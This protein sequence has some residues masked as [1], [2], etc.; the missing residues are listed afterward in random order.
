MVG[1]TTLVDLSES[2]TATR[3]AVHKLE[4]TSI[5]LPLNIM[6]PYQ[7]VRFCLDVIKLTW[8]ISQNQARLTILDLPAHCQMGT[9]LLLGKMALQ[10]IPIKILLKYTN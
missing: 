8:M 10:I 2:I 1:L 3:L 7:K 5:Y 4:V 9:G 6:F